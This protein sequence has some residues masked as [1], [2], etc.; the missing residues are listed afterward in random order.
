MLNML[1]LG[2]M[3][4]GSYWAVTF[5]ITWV[6]CSHMWSFKNEGQ[7]LRPWFSARKSV[8]CL[9]KEGSEMLPQTEEFM[10]PP[11][12]VWADPERQGAAKLGYLGETRSRATAPPHWKEPV[13][14]AW[15]FGQDVLPVEVFQPRQFQRGRDPRTDPGHAGGI[16]SL[17]WLGNALASHRI[18]WRKWPGKRTYGCP[19][20]SC[21]QY[22]WMDGW[23]FI[24]LIFF[25]LSLCNGKTCCLYLLII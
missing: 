19:Y 7:L 23:I 17:S 25:T 21:C 4:L 9:L 10:F 6:V 24:Y 3:S 2:G 1:C 15:A 18:T 16:I 8:D 20:S 22:G 13:E 5:S 14:V 12:S 11:H